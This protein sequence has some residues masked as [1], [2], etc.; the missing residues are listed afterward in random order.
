MFKNL[1]RRH[2]FEVNESN[3]AETI[4]EE[5]EA[6]LEQ[7]LESL[8]ETVVEL[9]EAIA[10]LRQGTYLAQAGKVREFDIYK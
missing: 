3:R 8:T 4:A 5:S 9:K 6:K 10:L 1:I 7:K 2:F